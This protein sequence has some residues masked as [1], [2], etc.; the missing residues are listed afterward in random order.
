M[1]LKIKVEYTSLG[2]ILESTYI[3][4]NQEKV[5]EQTYIIDRDHRKLYKNSIVFKD[6]LINDIKQYLYYDFSYYYEPTGAEIRTEANLIR[7]I[8]Y[9]LK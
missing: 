5:W 2:V 7:F 4:I 1:K 3:K 9:F 8:Q 6:S